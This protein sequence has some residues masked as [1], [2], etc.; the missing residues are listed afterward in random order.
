M[1]VMRRY[2]LY[3]LSILVLV[4]CSKEQDT[5]TDNSVNYCPQFYAE[6]DKILTRTYV[7]DSLQ[8]RW[9]ANDKLSIFT[10]TINQMYKFDGNTGDSDGTFSV[11]ESDNSLTETSLSVDANYAV[12]PY[13][14]E[15]SISTDGI[16]TF[17]LPQTQ[18]YNRNGFGTNSNLMIAVTENRTDTYLSF[19]NVC[20]YLRLYLYGDSINVKSIRLEGNQSEL[21]S[22]KADV[23][24]L[25]GHEP[26][27]SM[28][29]DATST[30]I[31]DCQ[32]GIQVGKSSSE[33][34]EFWFVV[35]PITFEKGFSIIVEDTEGN[36]Y[37]KSTDKK[38]EI[39]RNTISNMAISELDQL[40]EYQLFEKETDG[41]DA[42]MTNNGNYCALMEVN[43][44][45]KQKLAILGNNKTDDK[46]YILI[47][48]L[49]IIHN[50]TLGNDIYSLL[51][52]EDNVV[53]FCNENW[54]CN[55]PY[56]KFKDSNSKIETRASVLTRNPIY[57]LANK[58]SIS[59]DVLDAPKKAII[60]AVLQS[61]VGDNNDLLNFL[62][63]AIDGLDPLE[64]IKWIDRVMDINYFGDAYILTLDPIEKSICDYNLGCYTTIPTKDTPFYDENSH[65]GVSY[66]FKIIMNLIEDL[67][68]GKVE[69]KKS[70]ALDYETWF[71]FSNLKLNTKYRYEPRLEVEYSI[72]DEAYWLSIGE[73]PQKIGPQ[74][75]RRSIYGDELSFTTGSVNSTVERIENEKSTSADVIC[76]FSDV[77]SGAECEILLTK[78]G[79]DFSLIFSGQPNK[80]NQ[81]VSVSGLTPSTTYIAS[82]R[83]IH[84]GIPYNGT[85]SVSFSTTSG[86]SGHLISV[87]EDQITTTSAVVKC[88]F[89]NVESGVVCGIFVNGEDGSNK[90][91]RASNVEYE[92]DV[93][94]SG[95]KPYTKYTCT[96]YVEFTYEQGAYHKEGNSL[97]FT[98]EPEPLPDLSGIWT[99][100]QT[101]YGEHS[102]TIELI[103]ES[104]TTHSATY[105]AKS[106]FYGANQLSVTINSDGSGSIGCWNT[107]GY[108]SS[109]SGTFNDSYT[110]LSG[111]R[112]Y[113]GTNSWANPGWWEE[114]SWSLHR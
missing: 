26:V 12:F 50:F 71:N 20:G 48:S 109:F 25:Y 56:N 5:I 88:Q 92:Q 23:T 89:S 8:L 114:E 98:T 94:I 44:D 19:K 65:R 42:V 4:S 51:Y 75:V 106:G 70:E 69:Y 83:I 110:M 22:G 31:L 93:T 38:V 24:M 13:H 15:T 36:K 78:E 18:L 1:I 72:S 49:G 53:V 103:L 10:S 80:D 6:F 28:A 108:T 41:I 35:P 66:S 14:K 111:D 32:D 55:I 45:S 2:Y 57:K 33:A 102:L 68:F 17:D 62:I 64:V 97:S 21:I 81:K 3:L 61:Q 39:K 11:I 90:T 73:D 27:V 86:P 30:I 16:V 7:N 58:I 60:L 105:N 91:V 67:L 99:F 76:S 82:S 95:L 40:L 85:N 107:Y 96:S 112:Y 34:T 37:S 77:P 87:P 100:D 47:D 54:A 59:L 79:T 84:K 29:D 113:Y 101:Y 74:K 104:S 46:D 63:D 43:N 9:N 52:S